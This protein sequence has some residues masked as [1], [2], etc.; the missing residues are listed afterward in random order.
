M[1]GQSHVKDVDAIIQ[2]SRIRNSN[3]DNPAL[4]SSGQ[5]V[6]PGQ[7]NESTSDESEK[8]LSAVPE[9]QGPLVSSPRPSPASRSTTPV[10]N[11]PQ[12]EVPVS[13]RTSSRLAVKATGR[14]DSDPKYWSFDA[15]NY[16]I[17]SL[18]KF[19]GNKAVYWLKELDCALNF[20]KGAVSFHY[21][22]F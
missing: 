4:F 19:G 13:V 21:S 16:I 3:S 5:N 7:S 2:G 10:S 11:T 22:C 18:G 1:D 14:E 17:K 15:G 6:P 8:P 9:P 20:P 12:V